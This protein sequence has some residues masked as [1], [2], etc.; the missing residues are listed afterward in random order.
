VAALAAGISSGFSGIWMGSSRLNARW[1]GGAL[2]GCSETAAAAA[3]GNSGK[4][5]WPMSSPA[6]DFRINS[7]HSFT[8]LKPNTTLSRFPSDFPRKA[9]LL[10]FSRASNRCLCLIFMTSFSSDFLASLAGGNSGKGLQG[11]AWNPSWLMGAADTAAVGASCLET[12]GGCA[13]VGPG[14]RWTLGASATAGITDGIS[15]DLLLGFSSIVTA[16]TSG[17]GKLDSSTTGGR[18]VW[19][20]GA[21]GLSLLGA[22]SFTG[23][24]AGT[25]GLLLG[26]SVS[27]G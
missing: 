2:G 23:T 18:E 14:S 9:K 10:Y 1:S 25:A 27:V 26:N 5:T 19:R 22:G 7:S 20:I 17:A 21:S 8:A 11:G 12:V 24:K 16:G 3:A 4:S 15:N 13:L 6:F